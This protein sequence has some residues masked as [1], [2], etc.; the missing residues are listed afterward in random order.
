VPVDYS[1]LV[2]RQKEWTTQYE[3]I[4]SRGRELREED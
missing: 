3:R 1:K 2:T 4:L